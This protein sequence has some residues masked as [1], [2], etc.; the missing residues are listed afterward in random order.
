MIGLCADTHDNKQTI[1]KAVNV[2]NEQN[3]EWVL[4]AGDFVAPFTFNIFEKLQCPLIGVRG[5]NDGEFAG[6]K[7]RFAAMKPGS[8]LYAYP[9]KF[10][11]VGLKIALHHYPDSVDRLIEE[12]RLD[13][14][15]YGHTHQVDIRVGKPM[16][17]NP[18]DASGWLRPPTIVLLNPKDMSYEVIDLDEK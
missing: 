12:N 10:E 7:T 9:A 14:I 1:I 11:L 3:V 18:G 4:H 6:L 15:V 2:F 5:N 8:R 16:A 17:I 13:L